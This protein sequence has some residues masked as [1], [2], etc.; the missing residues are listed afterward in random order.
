MVYV[1]V[2]DIDSNLDTYIYKS[3]ESL[4][5]DIVS[6]RQ[7]R[8]VFRLVVTLVFLNFLLQSSFGSCLLLW[9]LILRHGLYRSS[10]LLL[11][12]CEI[13]ITVYTEY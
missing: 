1:F 12:S 8:Q 11:M 10:A 3:L 2:N 6:I 9:F 5:K 7:F 4:A 13:S